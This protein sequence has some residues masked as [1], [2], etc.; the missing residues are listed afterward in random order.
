LFIAEFLGH[1]AD[2]DKLARF[3]FPAVI[4]LFDVVRDRRSS[5]D[6]I[7]TLQHLAQWAQTTQ[8]MK[9]K[10]KD[11]GAC[12]ELKQR[13]R[14]GNP[15]FKRGTRFGIKAQ[16]FFLHDQRKTMGELILV[17]NQVDGAII[18]SYGQLV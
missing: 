8:G 9:L 10:D 6:D 14:V 7:G 4:Q 16:N 18:R 15:S 3:E 11:V 2:F 13:G 5:L 17:V 1:G 12:G